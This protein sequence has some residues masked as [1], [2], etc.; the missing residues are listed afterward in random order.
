MVAVLKDILKLLL[1]SR[2]KRDVF[3]VRL[4]RV[5]PTIE[6][7]TMLH[8]INHS[9]HSIELRDWGFIEADGSF[10][11]FLM[12]WE[13]GWLQSEDIVSQGSRK[14]AARGAFF[15]SGYVCRNQ[16]FGAYAISV[17]QNIPRL[18]FTSKMPH[19]RRIWIRLRLWF[20]PHYLAW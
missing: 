8:V 16:P 17:M 14:L 11:S 1:K 4:G 19:W 13:A 10:R 9:E 20:Q 5:S 12:E 15:E 3:V 18:Y 6:R 7:E 2:G